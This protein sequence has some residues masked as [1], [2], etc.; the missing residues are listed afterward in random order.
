VTTAPVV[1][2]VGG[3]AVLLGSI[4]PARSLWRQTQQRRLAAQR[5]DVLGAGT[6]LRVSPGPVSTL[7]AAHDSLFALVAAHPDAVG[8]E[9]R[10]AAHAAVADVAAVLGGAAPTAPDEIAFVADRADALAALAARIE[11]AVAAG[12]GAPTDDEARRARLAARHE[13]DRIEG[14]SSADRLRRL[15]DERTSGDDRG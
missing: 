4:L 7:V 10:A 14:S 1:L 8:A 13:V 6:P 15:A 3:G 12:A 5:A 11:A 9:E 2:A